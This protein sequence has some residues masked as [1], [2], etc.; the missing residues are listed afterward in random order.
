MNYTSENI[1]MTNTTSYIPDYDCCVTFIDIQ[2][3]FLLI[4]IGCIFCCVSFCCYKLLCQKSNKIRNISNTPYHMPNKIDNNEQSN[5]YN[6][7]IQTMSYQHTPEYPA[8]YPVNIAPI[9]GT[10]MP[11]QYNM[12][13]ILNSQFRMVPIQNDTK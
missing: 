4:F 3:I 7:N 1:T 11:Y 10:P 2:S 8:M 13:P 5:L 6:S 9:I 12:T